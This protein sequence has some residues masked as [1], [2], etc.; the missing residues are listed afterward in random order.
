MNGGRFV[1]VAMP[2][3][4][5]LGAIITFLIAI[6]TGVT[7]NNLYLF[8]VNISQLDV[9]SLSLGNLLDTAGVELPGNVNIDDIN[10]FDDLKK[11]AEDNNVDIDIDQLRE[12]FGD[13]FDT[14]KDSLKNFG[15]N[16]GDSF[17]NLGE[18]LGNL[19][20]GNNKVRRQQTENI[21][22]GDLGLDTFYEVTLW[23]YCSKDEQ[24]DRHC[25]KHQFDWA[26]KRINMSFV[27]S[28]GVE[29]PKE[30]TDAI[31]AFSEVTKWT[32]VAFIAALLALGVELL[33]GIFASC[34]RVMSCVTFVIAGA[35]STLS[36]I[37]AG[38]ATGM[39]LIIVGAVEGSDR[40]YGAKAKLNTSYLTLMW[41]G[42]AF[43]LAAGLFWVFTICCCAPDHGRNRKSKYYD[44]QQPMMGQS[45]R[46]YAPLGH[47]QEM[48]GGLY[49]NNQGYNNQYGR[50]PG[51]HSDVAYE[52]YAHR[53]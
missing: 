18:E 50:S 46:G 44:G 14:V 47:D 15:E 27:E 22:A 29:L 5:V 19:F 12:Q 40:L 2:L 13:N 48:S 41:I 49:N 45:Q 11:I 17:E 32:E 1:C 3:L 30:L 4:L 9:D 37:A 38:M 23:N 53:G 51:G 33:M 6:L 52:P 24:G 16:T 34:T 39:A 10:S 43:A 26:H 25:V 28:S 7:Q 42:V 21:T 8:S 20:N 36:I 31:K 35:A